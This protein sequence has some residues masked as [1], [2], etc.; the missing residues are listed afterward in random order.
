LAGDCGI[1]LGTMPTILVNVGQAFIPFAVP[2]GNIPPTNYSIDFD[3]VVNTAGFQDI[4]NW[5]IA[6]EGGIRI[7]IPNGGWGIPTGTYSGTL[8]VRS[9]SPECISPSYPVAVTISSNIPTI[10]E[11]PTG[12]TICSGNTANLNVVA[13]GPG[14][15]TVYYQW[16]SSTE[17]NGTYRDVIDGTGGTTPNY[18]TAI[19]TATTYYRVN[20]YNPS[21]NVISDVAVVTVNSPQNIGLSSS[22]A[23]SNTIC[24]GESV[25]F[26]AWGGITY[27]FFV[28][29]IS[30][31]PASSVSTFT[32]NALT[33]G[34]EVTVEIN[35]GGECSGRPPGIRTNVIALPTA[36]LTSSAAPSN[37]ICEGEQVTFTASG[38]YT[39]E[40]FVAGRSQGVRFSN[41]FTTDNLI[42]NQVV[43]VKITNIVGCSATHPGISTTV[44]PL[45]IPTFT[46]QPGTYACAGTE[47]T[48]T[49]QSGQSNYDWHLPGRLDTDYS[50]TS[51]GIGSTNYTVTLKWLTTGH[52]TVGIN[53]SNQ[54]GC[55]ARHEKSSTTTDV[56]YC[57]EPPEITSDGGG[58]E[59]EISVDEN[60]TIIT[61]VTA[62]DSDIPPQTLTYSISG[63]DDRDKFIINSVTGL[64]S[65]KPAPD[66]DQ[67]ASS[68][69]NNEYEVEVTVTDNGYGYKKDEQEIHITV[70]DINEAPVLT[71]IYKNG[72]EN[73]NVN[74]T[75]SDFTNAFTDV[76]GNSLTK[77]KIITLPA[78]GDLRLPWRTIHAGDEIDDDDLHEL[79]FDPDHDWNGSTSFK[80]NGFDGKIYATTPALVYIQIAP[81]NNPPTIGNIYKSKQEDNTVSFAIS[82]FTR[83]FH[84][85][86]GNV[87][88]KVK[89][90]TLPANGTLNLSGSVII[91]GQE[92]LTA[93]LSDL[94]FVPNSNWNGSTTFNWNG[95]DGTVY[96]ASSA[97]V[98]ITIYPV[99]DPPVIAELTKTGVEDIVLPFTT[100]GFTAAFEDVDGDQLASVKIVSLPANGT[101]KFSG[102]N[103]VPGQEI[104][105]PNIAFFTFLP[106]PDWNGTT[107]F[108][109]NG[110][111]GNSYAATARLAYLT[112]VPVNDRPTV[113]DIYVSGVANNVLSFVASDFTNAFSDIDG[114]PLV[115][116][117][118]S[119][120]PLNGTLNLSGV[121]IVA[122]D[123]ILAANLAGITFTP[124]TNWDG[125][126]SFRWNG[127]DGALYAISTSPVHIT[128]TP[129]L[130]TPPVI[131]DFAK[132]GN[133]DG[134]VSFTA[135]D[136]SGAF[137]DADAGN[138]LTKVRIVTL[139]LDGVLKLNG[140][141]I[142]AGV[143]LATT[144]LANLSYIPDLNWNGST[145]FKW[146]GSDGTAYAVTVKNVTITISP[147]NDPPT[148][149]Q[150]ARSGNEDN[151]LSFAVADFTSGFSDVDGNSLTTIKIVTLPAN[152]TLQLSNVNII[153]GQ[154]IPI[155]NTA[156]LTFVPD[157]NWN[158]ATSFDWN[159]SDGLLY[160]ATN[161]Q[162][163]ITIEPANDPPVVANINKSGTEDNTLTFAVTDFTGAFSDLENNSL[164]KI[165]IVSLPANGILQLFGVYITDGQEI[166]AANLSGITFIPEA[167][168][169]GTTSF[170]WNGFD[171]SDY[172]TAN[173]DVNLSLTATNDLPAVSVIYKSGQED[174]V[175][176]F[177]ASDFTDAFSDID[178]NAL[179][180]VKVV[181]LPTGGILQLSG[182]AVISGQE[183]PAADLANLSFVPGL[184]WNGAATFEWNGS[185][186]TAYATLSGHV[187]IAIDPV[188][189]APVIV[190]I[191]KSG[192]EDNTIRF[193]ASDFT[194]AFTDVEG[195]SLTKIKITF[196]ILNGGNLKLSGTNI[197]NNQEIPV[198][199]LSNIT[200]VPDSNYFG[201]ST[202]RWNGYDGTSYATT[203]N[204]I[205]II[206]T[207]VNDP[208]VLG[209]IN[210]SGLED[211][212]INFA[213]SDFIAAFSDV[214]DNAI[215]KIKIISLPTGGTLYLLNAIIA[216]G[217]E[218][219]ILNAGD[220]NFVP[221]A[222][223]NG[224]TTFSWNGYDGNV[225]A[226]AARQVI[227]NMIAVNDPPTV[228]NINKS[229]PEDNIVH[230]A[231]TDFTSK[232]TD[233]DGDF[234]TKIRITFTTLYGGNLQLS[235]TNIASGQE[236]SAADLANITFVPDA[237]YHGITVVRW[238]GFDGLTYATINGVIAI[239]TTPV[240][241]LPVLGD[242]FKTSDEDN[243]QGFTTSDFTDA[244][245]DADADPMTKVRIVTL[246]LQGIL[247]LS[248][249]EVV[250]G[251][252]IETT[253]L[254]NLTYT[255]VGN[256]YGTATFEWN[257][258]DGTVY[259]NTN[260]LVY[261][262]VLPVNDPP[263]L[264]DIN[265]SGTE[266][267]T[268]TF[269]AT[270]FTA[271]FTDP[272][273][274]ALT[275][276]LITTL[277][278]NGTLKLSGIDI[279][280][281]EEIPY[282]SLS[283]ITFVPDV[284]WNGTTSFNWNGFDGTTY[285]TDSRKVNIILSAVND[286]PTLND[287]Y[288]SGVENSTINFYS[289]D[290]TDA[291]IDPDGDVMRKITIMS[292]PFYGGILKLSGAPVLLGQ[293]IPTADLSNIT[294]V[295]EVDWTGSTT[296]SWNG[297]D[298]ASYAATNST[299]NISI[300]ALPNT[301]PVI[302][303]I[304][305]STT[306]DKNL[307]F[308]ASDFTG[309]FTD[310]DN[311]ALAKVKIVTLPLNGTLKL[312]G[313]TIQAGQEIPASMLSTLIFV[314]KINWNGISSFKWNG[315]DGKVYAKMDQQVII[316]VSPAN[317]PPVVR[318][319]YK[320]G[321]ED[322]PVTFTASDFVLAFTDIESD[323]LS[324]V[325]IVSLPVNGTLKLSGST[326]VAGQEISV[327]NLSNIT[328]LPNLHWSGIT[329]FDWNGFD[330]KVYA[331]AANQ[332]ILSIFPVNDPP[333]LADIN[334]STAEDVNLQFKASDFTTAFT[335]ADG[336]PLVKV[337]IVSLPVN[338]TLKLS[339][340]NIQANQE[341]GVLLL[342]QI[343]FVPTANWNGT[344]SF[345]WNGSDGI[346]YAATSRKV[347]I[348]VTMLNDPPTVSDIYKS[349][350]EDNTL[351]FSTSDFTNAFS[352]LDGNTL[353]KI[354][355]TSLPSGGELQLY[356]EAISPGDE[357]NSTNLEY[358]TFVPETN[359]NGATSFGWNGFDGTVYAATS[360]LVRIS[361][362][363]LNDPPIVSDIIKTGTEDQA[364]KFTASD[365]TNAFN[366]TEG[367][368][369]TK[370][371]VV[372]LP[373]NG[374]LKQSGT[375]I[376]A[377]QEILT[378]N[379]GS[380]TF[381]PNANW[382]GTTSFG[383]NG[384]DG[385]A[386]ATTDRLV[387]ISLGPVNDL[388][389]LNDIY[390]QG[391]EDIAL[392]F[393]SVDFTSSFSDPDGDALNKV[394]INSLPA[395][396]TLKLSG[397]AI[398]A[399]QEIPATNLANITFVPHLNWNGNTFF[400]WNGSDGTT[401]ATTSRKV[402]L[403]IASV[404]DVPTVGDIYKSGIEN[405]TITF[406]SADYTDSF[407]DVD[408]NA[409]SR[410]KI[411]SLPMNGILKLSG[412]AIAAGEE[413]SATN[414]ANITFDPTANWVGVTTF[415]WNGFDGTDYAV[416]NDTVHITISAL[417]NT[418]PVV[419][420]FAKSTAEDNLLNFTASDFISAF[421]DAEGNALV[422]VK[423]RSLPLGGTLMLSGAAIN[424]DQEIYTANLSNLTFMPYANLAGTTTFR[425]NGF[426]GKVYAMSTARVNI[427]ITAVNDA[428]TLAAITKSGTEDNILTFA[429]S[430]FTNAFTDVDGN[431][432]AKVRIATL[433][434]NGTLK[435]SGA[436]ITVGTEIPAA[437]LSSIT[438]LPDA[439]WNGT[440]NYEWNGYDGTIY[441]TGN[442][443]VNITI[444]PSNDP[445]TVVDIGKSG[446][447]DN[448]LAFATTDF[449]SAFADVD[450]NTLTKVMIASL[451]ASGTLKLSGSDITAGQEIALANLPGITYTPL[452]DWN[453]TTSF[454]WNGSD[455]SLYAPAQEQVNISISPVNDLP[456]VSTIYKSGQEDI[457]LA[458]TASDFTDA[459]TDV[460][461]D[462][463][464]RI[465]IV[466]LP[467]DGWLKLS[468]NVINVGQEIPTA[469]LANLTFVPDTDWYGSTTFRW[470]GSDGVSYS[471]LSSQV[472][473]SYAGVN[474]PP[475]LSD[476]YKSG[477][478]DQDILFSRSDFTDVFTDLDGDELA[479]GMVVTI[480]ANGTLLLSGVAV[481]AGQEI[482]RTDNNNLVFRPDDNWNGTTSFYWNG[483]DGEAYAIAASQVLITIDAVN[484]PPTVSNIYKSGPEDSNLTFASADFSNAFTDQDGNTLNRIKIISLPSEGT[485]KLSGVPIT[486]GQEIPAAN[487]NNI[488]FVPET[489]WNGTTSF[490]WN[491]FD[492][493]IYA[494]TSSEV[495][496]SIYPVNDQPTIGEIYVTG[497]E[498]GIIVFNATYFTDAFD[499]VD[500]NS[501][502]KV[503]IVSLP[504]NGLLKLS[505]M[506][507]A[508]GEEITADNLSNLSFIPDANW[509]GSTSFNWNGSDGI[510]YA[511]TNSLVQIAITALPNTP[512]VISDITKST[513]EDQILTFAVT[514]FTN[515]FTD[516]DG[517]S[518]IKIRILRLP[519]DGTLKLAGTAIIPGQE[520][521]TS[522]L[523]N[524]TF[525][526]GAN[527]N[528][529]TFF[530]WNGFDGTTYARI[531]R[532]V[533]ITITPVNDLPTL[534]N[535]YK[536]S[537]E[538]NNI[539]FD[540]SDFTRAFADADG[541]TLTK[542]I[543]L[544]LPSNGVLYHS[545]FLV[546]AGQEITNTTL[547]DLVFVPNADWHGSTSFSWN[548]F[549]GS[550]YATTSGLVSLSVSPV[551]D[552][553]IVG[554]IIKA[555]V[556]DNT[557]SFLASDFT[558]AFTDPEGN[559]LSSVKFTTLPAD[560]I[561]R[562]SGVDI[563]A[564]QEIVAA[565]LSNISFVPDTNW[566]GATSFHWNGSDGTDYSTTAGKVDIS[567]SPVNDPPTV[568][569]ITK[570]TTE[571]ST[572]PFA[573]SD[574]TDAFS[575]KD[576]NSL[577]KVK[578]R[579]LPVGGTL[580]LSGIAVNPDQEIPAANLGDLTFAPNA[581]FN[582]NTTFSWNG[583]DGTVYALNTANVNI[584][585]AAVNDL[586]TVSDI[587]KAGTENSIL[588]FA[589]S[590]FTDSFNDVD[591]NALVKIKILS[592]PA[593]G[594]LK[595]SG[596]AI[597]AGDEIL[598]ANLSL[599]TFVPNT[600]WTG[601]TSFLWNGFNGTT[602]AATNASV[603]IAITALP[604]HPPVVSDIAVSGTEDNNFT[605]TLANFTLAFSD[606]DADALVKVRIVTLPSNGLLN[607]SGIAVTAGQEIPASNLSNL[608]F[609]P[610]LNWNGT[611]TFKWNG[612][613]GTTYAKVA[614][615]VSISI[616]PVND[617]PTLA[618]VYK[619]G[620]EDI[621]LTFD[622][623][624][625]FNGAF[626]DV[627]SSSSTKVRII[628]LPANGTLKLSG[629]PVIAGEEIATANLA[630]ITFVP[631][632]NWSGTTSITWN[633]SDGIDYAVTAAQAILTIAPVNDQPL[634]TDIAKSGTEDILLP[635]AATDFTSAYTDL[636]GTPL[637]KVRIVT[638][639]VNGTLQLSGGFIT[640]GQEIPA[641]SLSGI[642]FLPNTNWHGA[643][644]F[645]WNGS[646]GTSYAKTSK[647]VNI[648]ISSVNDAPV[649]TADFATVD[650]E[651][652]LKGSSLLLND[653]DPDG[654][655]LIINTLPKI[656]PSHGTLLI[657]AD[658]TFVY[659]PNSNFNG[660]DGF[661]YEVCDNVA[662]S[663]CSTVSVTITIIPVNDPPVA[664]APSVTTL[665]DT[666]V[667]GAVTA[668]DP[669]GD[670]L[671]FGASS[672]PLH[673][674]V[675]VNA[676]GSFIYTPA[677]N[678]HGADSFMVMVNDGHGG[679][680]ATTVNVTILPV[681]DAPVVPAL[682]VTT[683]EDKAFIG[684][685]TGT[686]VDGDVLTFSKA[687]DPA[688]GMVVV[689]AGGSFAYTPAA[690]YNGSDSFAVQV[691]DGNG[692]TAT[693]TI[694]VTIT[695]VND[696]PSF[697]NGGNQVVCGNG[698]QQ[699]VPGWAA[700]VAAGPANESAQTVKFTV[701]NDNNSLFSIQPA[702]DASGIL[703]YIPA[704]NQNGSAN[705]KVLL[706]DD[707]G[708]LHGGINNSA[709]Q[710]FTI[711]MNALPKEPALQTTQVFC[712]QATIA[713]LNATAPA[714][715]T[716]SWFSAQ[717]G[718]N[719]LPD[720]YPLVNGT[721]YYVEST[722]LATGCKSQLRSFT[723][724]ILNEI[725]AAPTGKQT[726][727]FCSENSPRVS[728]LTTN[729]LIVK[730]YYTA[731]GG[732]EIPPNT[733]LV[734]GTKYYATQ[735]S[736]GCESIFRLAV[737]VSITSCI[738]PQN[739][740]P[741]VSDLS[742][743]TE[744]NQPLPFEANDFTSVYTDED[745]D[746]LAKI[747]IE[748]VPPNGK[749]TLSGLIVS[750]GLEILA[751]DL[752]NLVFTP[753]LHFS[754]ESSFRWSATDGKD[755]AITSAQVNLSI[756]PMNAFIPEGFSP[757]GDGIN[758]YFVIKRAGNYKISFKI[759]NRWSNK[760]F[761]SD[762]YQNDWGGIANVGSLSGKKVD[763]GTYFYIIDF[764]NGEM[765]KVSYIT[766]M[767]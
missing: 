539:I 177:V 345:Q 739:H 714:G 307:Q 246:P 253:E 676:N 589:A 263:V 463:M 752:G 648:N 18:T 315:S 306:E 578:I 192:P 512:P 475:T 98:N 642:T 36:V 686:D 407:T 709:V 681:N 158:G 601:I 421:T 199:D 20:V 261:L 247:K 355:V 123:E 461:N 153:A 492:G 548:G 398:S 617:P 734:N 29:G 755:Y 612:S 243:V 474:D 156:L 389:A 337:K 258:H 497:V 236:I 543:I 88:N 553:P 718:G 54:F 22:A 419:S 62:T 28:A 166:D 233:A 556:E 692:G 400:N 275:K 500:G 43:T 452:K 677:I 45:P 572:L 621:I 600:N 684:T 384:H 164:T 750:P 87:L 151:L 328:F 700:P 498:N 133:E 222:D 571:D 102:V 415:N 698:T 335:D 558:D 370:V 516:A 468:G 460:E 50:I 464:T 477:E 737:T 58:S 637:A 291:F 523:A 106:D 155:A 627:E 218:I 599:I 33:N 695:P 365:F 97:K 413:I 94:N 334:K 371:K 418:A 608:T 105:R 326:I 149:S 104:T 487:L 27:E 680:D 362:A 26:T 624:T 444:H 286:S 711:T 672:N 656:A 713:D 124:A 189:D 231:S 689:N 241:D 634:L 372:S 75:E 742:K 183:V 77:V 173:K 586:P 221:N 162:V 602:Y 594:A 184:N 344:T 196:A 242:I 678:Y 198:A 628:T 71:D 256:W 316:A 176:S 703:F 399:G 191:V 576:G 282:A 126:T 525:D 146:N 428:P 386:Y 289:T 252:E 301:E 244:Y 333:T 185:D 320:A 109:W 759:Y 227:I 134:T 625:D 388:P 650:E 208:P 564:D 232:F 675:M 120:L 304:A 561:L 86:D 175:L 373:A 1:I 541:N 527:I 11:Q 262:Y 584:T 47:V 64:L 646:D 103:V 536:S 459:Y 660:I 76:D 517:N 446:T 429:S 157:G 363:P 319:I 732:N 224:T 311:D 215:T 238:N 85:V 763:A 297:F 450:G 206:V 626:T 449:T 46:A 70:L 596:S 125:S 522:E 685:A 272:D 533:N 597:S 690:D 361:L 552:P 144:D 640:A 112:I 140:T 150:I 546:N 42:N 364:V 114:N 317:D 505:G 187:N 432:L 697:G 93:N 609:V 643:T 108:Y 570:T 17:Y 160:A 616:A 303:P 482:T 434:A 69:H 180:K 130:N 633:A 486:A 245:Q 472:N 81:V 451:P 411:F 687:A 331:N 520:I 566:S 760:V 16:Q 653:S 756:I 671:T 448:I 496:L 145:S 19:L 342:S 511:A 749:L 764:N 595:I 747:R 339:G 10:I 249:V 212:S 116:V 493:T 61:T 305:K 670:Q 229:G 613:D 665:E 228:S 694:N 235:G 416:A 382:N 377:G 110:S 34:Q 392:N 585:V 167:N 397:V 603:N 501:L 390:K 197:T 743:T 425:W 119:T 332:V 606:V 325:K 343:I 666:P 63:G 762:D 465:K 569:D 168:W 605:F 740:P 394:M 7:V 727:A 439:N 726:Q 406:N 348:T 456:T 560:G 631:D 402:D 385:T 200:F 408:G 744:L 540:A 528:G 542:I 470:R 457:I 294:F 379:L 577:V 659:T 488:T 237:N 296:F 178:G 440:T 667:G 510:T 170:V 507:I 267:N 537:Q 225:Y 683:L 35:N 504:L 469:N 186:G 312:L 60:S 68:N 9:Y 481:V 623:S 148:L 401:Y 476:V 661:V 708:I 547:S 111:D 308:S 378:A 279:A 96:A 622:P 293:E 299:T 74:F 480:P 735:T 729:A 513:I 391:D 489:N 485:L 139:P 8:T 754:G 39:Y 41:I 757:N 518:L 122:G 51:G 427:T 765:A 285:A 314:P 129:Q 414:L 393:A 598:A 655:K 403:F 38:G 652:T 580:M 712:G 132:S 639:P 121:P 761:E 358:I 277:P 699:I 31:G 581:N 59:A 207:P 193:T 265:K 758:D 614:A 322:K 161:S 152:G 226:L 336:N 353:A 663:L 431:A 30:Q 436:A 40:F 44:N 276:V 466:A 607:L 738:P 682:Q 25:T 582:G 302:G 524:L 649:L 202:V 638:L 78:H 349:G 615:Q 662:P 767:Y 529:T 100:L 664:S 223:W 84:D 274:D 555:G 2:P 396:G 368:A 53:Y 383:W 269:A 443:L 163:N 746:R 194:G 610:K 654:D 80:W 318:A 565:N 701:T 705:V 647:L 538:D 491:G 395:N 216:I 99:N 107:S 592:L 284:N 722:S 445:P 679:N 72:T 658:G 259:S 733:L 338:G 73:Q 618:N 321:Q 89:I 717:T 248:G 3:P 82:D 508:A 736:N 583:F 479:G 551:N 213:A 12:T 15:S 21:S 410:I 438:F 219:S 356:G 79:Y 483:F 706:T 704:L 300:E 83:T 716:L 290:F 266:D 748:S 90:E 424:P 254:K 205:K 67:P 295:P 741:V 590:D 159:G 478:E 644:S 509:K 447:E 674:T 433:P 310:P 673:G 458:F 56:H 484:D 204:L 420:D 313:I 118:I 751:A 209:N 409:L 280:A 48:Y 327:L 490:A 250:A 521:L 641:A 719:P 554:E 532:K 298:G 188:N 645:R 182:V 723:V 179:T 724:A 530:R 587:Y 171:G 437:N 154:E 380:I 350:Q 270:D 502:T 101:L 696:A 135:A 195:D 230:F 494:S 271:K 544:T 574:F 467:L 426:D 240:N 629:V 514:D 454:N 668:T 404:N 545:G 273:G 264:S 324:K 604:N 55:T 702:I 147:L 535:I 531:P 731:T 352:D 442:Q 5:S 417:P 66:F 462:P 715:S 32:T 593:N 375:A 6:A 563:T 534:S 292:L 37:T 255:P 635:F 190:E 588:S 283:G 728:D 495:T 357:I 669:D 113:S 341:I 354:K 127:Y 691:S 506:A 49:T 128:I 559:L 720:S 573:S 165:M 142:D 519:A 138:V 611:A 181:S 423:I 203:A 211:N 174:E 636:E 550:A 721:I 143:E 430:D 455:G 323:P 347:I 268:I 567:I 65:F 591:G 172:A 575:D 201:P 422:K 503:K 288:K 329:R 710:T 57:N 374:I 515:A 24:A 217:D 441:A 435:L 366:D 92:I 169:Y 471:G 251:A 359:W 651:A 693:G 278:A 473:I 453:G 632:A 730:W 137:T 405:T 91:A 360:R 4:S 234:M 14:N 23:P 260:S 745:N 657:N 214:D 220:I 387:N 309:A 330:G 562:L 287:I 52:K 239:T 526:P 257:G 351:L 117:K 412:T 346:T 141:P 131:S 369:L 707:G 376:S 115:K 688:H 630:N 568:G 620:T 340:T 766:I 725:P 95:S 557:L 13:V 619:S 549:D 367:S 499:D 753:D 381:E 281:E 136:F 210:K 579:T